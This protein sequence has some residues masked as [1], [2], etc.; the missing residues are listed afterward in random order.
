MPSSGRNNPSRSARPAARSK[1]RRVAL[2]AA[3]SR[4][5]PDAVLSSCEGQLARLEAHAIAAGELIVGRFSEAD[6]SGEKMRGPELQRLLALV[7]NGEVDCIKVWK[8]SRLVREVRLFYQLLDRVY[9]A[10]CEI[11][12]IAPGESLDYETS[13]GRLVTG[14]MAAIDQ[15]VVDTAR[16]EARQKAADRARLGYHNGHAP[17]GY[18]REKL[19]DEKRREMLAT[20]RLEPCPEEAPLLRQLFAWLDEFQEMS[21]LVRLADQAGYRTRRTER[22]GGR[23]FTWQT[24][25][26]MLT[27]RVYLGEVRH[28]NG[29]I[30]EAA[31]YHEA[32]VEAQLFERVQGYAVRGLTRSSAKGQRS[33][34]S[35]EWLLAGR[36]WCGE[37]R[38][39]EPDGT[40][41]PRLYEAL[42]PHYA[43]KGRRPYFYY[44]RASTTR[45]VRGRELL[46]LGEVP[47]FSSR[48]AEQL[49]EQVLGLVCMVAGA[50][51][52]W[53]AAQRD[54]LQ[55]GRAALA[56]ISHQ[57]VEFL[58]AIEELEA[59]YAR[60]QQF[61]R[62]NCADEA[63]LPAIRAM[64]SELEAAER[65]ILLNERLLDDC[66]W[67][68]RFMEGLEQA[69]V[70]LRRLY[71]RVVKHRRAGRLRALRAA[72]SEVLEDP[73]GVVLGNGGAVQV[74]LRLGAHFALDEAKFV[75]INKNLRF[76]DYTANFPTVRLLERLR[77]MAAG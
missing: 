34:N 53:Q 74:N 40:R 52:V 55:A 59:D 23:R 37:T 44:R 47:D 69:V 72:L 28:L 73:Y 29:W 43:L 10:G 22:K 13:H 48:N 51:D 15:N 68:A 26:Y 38:E 36:V 39:L 14:I 67:A 54:A 32:L 45:R 33:N 63:L 64:Q 1:R 65:G 77:R 50:E 35:R 42:E 60:M 17:F 58:G 21:E 11:E 31:P 75:E 25:Q 6:V 56:R 62:A 49:E 57:R 27:N 20:G 24:L 4:S 30:S 9:S 70:E 16:E 18:R 19:Y 76:L 7:D 12:P 71:L 61:I 66:D 2:Y 3:Q 8:K 5:N 41:E 46:V